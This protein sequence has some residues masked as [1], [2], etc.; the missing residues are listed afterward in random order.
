MQDNP[1]S[2]INP[3]G[4]SEEMLMKYLRGELSQSMAHE[5]EKVM[6]DSV[7]MNDA[8][9]G[10]ELMKGKEQLPQIK[11]EIENRLRKQLKKSEIKKSKRRIKDFHWIYIFIIIIILLIIISYA[12]VKSY[13]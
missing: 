1:D 13:L 6:L 12:V 9:E 7:F 10:L 2:Y 3:E 4:I 11:K 8:A 5:V